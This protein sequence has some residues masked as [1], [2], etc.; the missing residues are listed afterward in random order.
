MNELA[1]KHVAVTGGAGFIGSHIADRAEAVADVTVYDNFSTGYR[2]NVPSTATIKECN[3]QE[4]TASDLDGVDIVFHEAAN[5]SI[6]RSMEAPAFDAKE[7]I[8][9][10]LTV[11]EAARGAGVERLVLA[12]SSAVYGSPSTLP[13]A[14]D[15]DPDPQAPYAVSKLAG[16]HYCKLYDSLYDLETVCLRYFN[17]YGPRQRGDSPYAGVIPI[18]I[19]RLLDG[20]QLRIYGD[21]EQTRDFVYVKDVV[22]ANV[23]AATRPGVNGGVYNVGTG[24]RVSINT[25]ADKLEELVEETG[26]QYDDPRTGDIRHSCADTD[27]FENALG[28]VP[29]T[30]LET[31]LAETVEWYRSEH[32]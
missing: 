28:F 21:G 18:F 17:V 5:I 7:N 16:E 23:R 13:V 4:M 8:L 9:G 19:E 32:R 22:E 26:R 12:S 31:G 29:A 11:L 27:R 3:I 14:E 6:P 30:D 20:S 24:A 10:L 25:V 1:G 15:A 2:E